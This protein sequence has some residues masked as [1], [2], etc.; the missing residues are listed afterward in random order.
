MQTYS[1]DL[2]YWLATTYLDG[3]GPIGLRQWLEK[4]GDI[5]NLFTMSGSDLQELGLATKQIES[6][7]KI[8]WRKVEEDLKWCEKNHCV[9]IPFNDERYPLLLKEIQNPPIVLF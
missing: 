3:I 6:I 1:A 7:K 9:L 8:N 5:K 2:L 4:F